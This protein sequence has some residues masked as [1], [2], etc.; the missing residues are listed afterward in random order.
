MGMISNADLV[1]SCPICRVDAERPT[2]RLGPYFDLVLLYNMDFTR[3][4]A[5]SFACQLHSFTV[6]IFL[7][8]SLTIFE[9]DD[10]H[11]TLIKNNMSS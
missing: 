7:H 2:K 11:N 3:L 5:C 4:S 10:V 1:A 9:L 6:I 8:Y